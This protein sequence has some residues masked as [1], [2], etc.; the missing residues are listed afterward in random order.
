MVGKPEVIIRTRFAWR[1]GVT[2]VSENLQFSAPQTQVA[3]CL[4]MVAFR[5]VFRVG[6]LAHPFWSLS[7][8]AKLEVMA[9]IRS[10]GIT[11]G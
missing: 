10:A 9:R 11:S 5:S 6:F 8:T 3:K 2:C 7:R 4:Y 1:F